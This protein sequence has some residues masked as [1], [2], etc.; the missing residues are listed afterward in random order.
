MREI[1]EIDALCERRQ[2]GCVRYS[3]LP[4]ASLVPRRYRCQPNATNEQV[5]IDDHINTA[6]TY[7]VIG[8]SGVPL[9]LLPDGTPAGGFQIA[10]NH[11]SLRRSHIGIASEAGDISVEHRTPSKLRK[12]LGNQAGLRRSRRFRATVLSSA[13]PGWQALSAR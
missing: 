5:A 4:L 3:H 7:D 8:Q 6:T 9:A 1:A 13:Q 2:G 12:G 10:R 11:P